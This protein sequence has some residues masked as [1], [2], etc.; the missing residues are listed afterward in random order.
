MTKNRI[1]AFTLSL[2]L[3]ALAGTAPLEAAKK[4]K[5]GKTHT[6]TLDDGRLE[7]SWFA[8]EGLPF[9]EADEADYLWVKDGFSIDGQTFHML[10]WEE[11][12]FI[13]EDA[14]ERDDED[15][16]MA[17]DMAERMADVL[18]DIWGDEW[19]GKATTSTSSGNVKVHGRIVDA[20]TGSAVAS[21]I[22][23][24]GAGSGNA[25]VDIKFVDAETGELLMALHHRETMDAN[26]WA[27]DEGD[28]QDWLE[29]LA[30]D[31]AKKG[32]GDLYANGGK[33]DD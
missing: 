12:D 5:S 18:A 14:G 32:F 8:A 25:T 2:G 33:V 21:A 30:E 15:E 19:E 20:T 9:R 22:V 1:L 29:E 13:G 27:T 17:E 4:D 16:D 10:P 11:P 28:F 7:V 24:W 31:V 6:G 23:G 3:A 26:W